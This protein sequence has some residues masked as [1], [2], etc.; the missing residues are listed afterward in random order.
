MLDILPK[1]RE[2]IQGSKNWHI[3]VSYH[4]TS[5]A[6]YFLQKVM[7]PFIDCT[8]IQEWVQSTEYINHCLMIV[9]FRFP[10]CE[11]LVELNNISKNSQITFL[12]PNGVL[13]NRM[14]ILTFL[15]IM[16][17]PISENFGA[18]T[19]HFKCQSSWHFF[20]VINISLQNA[21]L[22]TYAP[23]WIK[24]TTSEIKRLNS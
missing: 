2:K 13:M 16:I 9:T 11:M 18:R 12:K 10:V 1:N 6:L 14:I 23:H 19:L 8:R 4:Q 22:T 7:F 15:S 20:I 24:Q 5:S 3:H 21:A 17:P